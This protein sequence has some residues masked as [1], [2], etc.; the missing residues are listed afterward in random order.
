V[1]YHFDQYRINQKRFHLEEA[2]KLAQSFGGEHGKALELRA[3]FLMAYE[4]RMNN[5]K[6]ASIALLEKQKEPSF[7]SCYHAQNYYADTLILLACYTGNQEYFEKAQK[8]F[9]G[10]NYGCLHYTLGILMYESTRTTS[11]REKLRTKAMKLLLN[12]NFSEAKQHV[13]IKEWWEDALFESAS[14]V[15]QYFKTEFPKG[16]D[17]ILQIKVTELKSKILPPDEIIQEDQ[18]SED[19]LKEIYGSDYTLLLDR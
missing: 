1:L 11:E 4:D 13:L 8:H 16:L 14:F 5:N 17:P 18:L 9:R 10:K 12:I 3:V 15:I 7:K 2:I 19:Q 6:A